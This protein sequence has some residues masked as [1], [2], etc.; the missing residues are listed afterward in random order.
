MAL[1]FKICQYILFGRVD[2]T[3]WRKL[4][5]K[6]LQSCNVQGC[7]SSGRRSAAPIPSPPPPPPAPP[8]P[9]PPPPPPPLPPPPT[10]APNTVP[11]LL[12]PMPHCLQEFSIIL[13]KT[14]EMVWW[15]SSTDGSTLEHH[16][17]SKIGQWWDNAHR[18][19]DCV[20]CGIYLFLVKCDHYQSVSN[21]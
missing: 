6:R 12:L 16:S 13:I 5:G 2:S 11:S 10:A 1:F 3:R 15:L 14:L 21:L 20:R 9:Y 19:T 17:E 7:R 18:K 8:P 4:F